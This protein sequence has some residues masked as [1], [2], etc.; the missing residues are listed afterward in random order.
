MVRLGVDF[1]QW[2][3]N[4]SRSTVECWKNN[5][6][7]HAVVQY[8]HLMGQHLDALHSVGGIDVEAYVYLYWNNASMGTPQSRTNRALD[9]AGNRISRLWLDAEDTTAPFNA[10]A[11]MECVRICERRGM[12]VGIYTGKWW[13]DAHSRGSTAF[14]DYPLWA[15]Q[16]LGESPT[17]NMQRMPKTTDGFRAFGGWNSPLIWQWH[18]TTTFCG[19]SVDLNTVFDEQAHTP[20]YPIGDDDEM[21]R[22]NAIAEWF[23]GRELAGGEEFYVMQAQADFQLPDDARQVTFCVWMD[24]GEVIFFDGLSSREAGRAGSRGANYVIIPDVW[25][26]DA[27]PGQDGG[28]T[29]N[30]QAIADSKIGRIFCLGYK[31]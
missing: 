8:S 18:N 7:T 31:R 19:H 26:A 16:Y 15:A 23:D 27:R 5:G 29:L 11:L 24:A 1:S 4:L 22:H 13:W 17:P 10:N 12:P 30:F 2:G 14:K 21:I 3:G 9:V 20:S 6:V 28:K 25:M